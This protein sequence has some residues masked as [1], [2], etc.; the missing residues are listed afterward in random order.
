MT[1]PKDARLLTELDQLIDD[2]LD[3]AAIPD[4]PHRLIRERAIADRVMDE[5]PHLDTGVYGV[6]RVSD[7]HEPVGE[8][9]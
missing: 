6:R 5:H 1:D 8:T 9:E 2:A 3:E 4:G 7:D